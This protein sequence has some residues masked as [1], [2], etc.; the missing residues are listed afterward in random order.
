MT[1]ASSPTSGPLRT[2]VIGLGMIGRGV[3]TSLVRSGL[4]PTAVFDVRAKAADDLDGVLAQSASPAAV[5]D[6]SDVVLLAVLDDAQA[7]DVL[8]GEDGIFT[9]RRDGLVVVLLST[10]PVEAVHELGALCAEHGAALLD[11]GVTG[12][13]QAAENGL[14]VMVGGPDEAVGRA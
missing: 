12:G 9:T 4:A 10:V 11:A 13:A 8:T 7:R 14:V 2:G 6:A 3:A 1:G 5:A